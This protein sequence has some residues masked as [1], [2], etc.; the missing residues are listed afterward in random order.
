MACIHLVDEEV[1]QL[2][3]RIRTCVGSLFIE[4][5]QLGDDQLID[6]LLQKN[7]QAIYYRKRILFD[8]APEAWID[9]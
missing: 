9:G 8:T 2:S 4:G 3:R 7:Q 5:H 1:D 6:A